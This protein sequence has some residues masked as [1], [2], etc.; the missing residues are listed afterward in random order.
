MS[1]QFHFKQFSPAPLNPQI[2]PPSGATT[3]VQSEPGSNNNKGALCIPQI[4]SNPGT[5][6]SDYSVSHL[7]HLLWGRGRLSAEKLSDPSS[8]FFFLKTYHMDTSSHR[9]TCKYVLTIVCTSSVTCTRLP[10]LPFQEFIDLQ[11]RFS[12]RSQETNHLELLV[13]TPA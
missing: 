10:I 8:F 9:Y 6:P 13:N 5:S 12:L 3:P 2:G 11:L 4:S 7:G 1:K